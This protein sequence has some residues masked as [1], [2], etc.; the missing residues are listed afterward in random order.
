[1]EIEIKNFKEVCYKLEK[2]NYDRT[3]LSQL[4]RY[5]VNGFDVITVPRKESLEFIGDLHNIEEFLKEYQ[6]EKIN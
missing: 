1:M 3:S 5:Y 6:I 4:T 2:S